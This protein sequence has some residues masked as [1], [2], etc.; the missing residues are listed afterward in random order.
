MTLEELKKRREMV[1]HDKSKV[2]YY[3]GRINKIETTELVNSMKQR[4][5]NNFDRGGYKCL[6]RN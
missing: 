4:V 6:E 3:D 5:S 1:Q 2:A